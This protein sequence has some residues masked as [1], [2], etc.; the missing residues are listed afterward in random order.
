M[1]K[2]IAIVLLL[3][4]GCTVGPDYHTPKTEMPSEYGSLGASTQPTTKPSTT[5]PVSLGLW[6]TAFDDPTL[7]A[8]IEQAIKSNPDLKIAQSRVLEARALRTIAGSAQ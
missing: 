3:V 5:Q 7:N 6:W 8:L 1:R 2:S 4:G